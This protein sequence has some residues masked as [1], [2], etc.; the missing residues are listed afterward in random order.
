MIRDYCHNYW[1]SG[2]LWGTAAGAGAAAAAAVDA[3]CS[4][5]KIVV[6]SVVVVFAG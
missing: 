5:T 6:R 3:D 4:S 2:P 1:A